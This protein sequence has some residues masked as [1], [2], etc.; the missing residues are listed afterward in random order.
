M[1]NSNLMKDEIRKQIEDRR[2]KLLKTVE[3]LDKMLESG[4]EKLLE[5]EHWDRV[6]EDFYNPSEDT[7]DYEDGLSDEEKKNLEYI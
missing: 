7:I 2:E 4:D 3:T 6:V 1:E 5:K